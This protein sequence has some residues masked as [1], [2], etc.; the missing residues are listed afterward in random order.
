MNINNITIANMKVTVNLPREQKDIIVDAL[1][2]YQE[3][4]RKISAGSDF[5]NEHLN[6]TDFDIIGLSG[7]FS[8]MGVDIR[9]EMT[10][11]VHDK[12]V[13]NHGVDFPEYV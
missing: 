13:H 12:F 5:Q 7:I 9:V 1:K 6:Y 10:E 2:V 3:A 4:I 8:D 11:E